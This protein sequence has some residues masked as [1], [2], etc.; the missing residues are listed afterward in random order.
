MDHLVID[1]PVH[2]SNAS[3]KFLTNRW[4]M[5]PNI[6]TK[7]TI[8]WNMDKFFFKNDEWSILPQHENPQN[9]GFKK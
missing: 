3:V 9:Q 5:L 6:S 1:G 8:F 4:F 7:R 2:F